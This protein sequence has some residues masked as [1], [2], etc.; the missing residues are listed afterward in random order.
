MVRLI[1]SRLRFIFLFIIVWKFSI[2]S[3]SISIIVS[4]VKVGLS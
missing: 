1:N 3:D 4:S 2:G